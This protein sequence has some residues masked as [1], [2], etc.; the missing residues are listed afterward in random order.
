MMIET[1][2]NIQRLDRCVG[3]VAVVD[4]SSRGRG[5]GR[6]SSFVLEANRN[7]PGCARMIRV[8]NLLVCH[9]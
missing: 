3:Q 1:A 5:R 6:Y 9:I 2:A 7:K 4:N 8:P